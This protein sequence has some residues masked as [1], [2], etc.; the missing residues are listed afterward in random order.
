M[1]LFITFPEM[2]AFWHVASMS[3]ITMGI[4]AVLLGGVDGS[5]R[6]GVK[7]GAVAKLELG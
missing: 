6:L 7:V 2:M 5:P 4:T 1:S 3:S